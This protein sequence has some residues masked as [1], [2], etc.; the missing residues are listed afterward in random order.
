VRH[1]RWL[2]VYAGKNITADVSGMITEI[3]YS[4]QVAHLSDEVEITLEDRDRTWQ[5]DWF[6]AR[7]D[8]VTLSIGYDGEELLTCGD[9]EVDELELMGPPDT[10]QLKC[11]AAGV[12]PSIRTYR[13]EKYESTTLL[14][15]AKQVAERHGMT[16]VGAPGIV[17]VTFARLTQTHETDL[18]FLR[19]LAQ[20]H[21]YDFSIRGQKGQAVTQIVFFER[22]RLE[23]V[24]AVL[25][26][27]R[28]SDPPSALSD[29]QGRAIIAKS[30]EFKSKTQQI[31]KSA[32]MSYQ[33]PATKQLIVAHVNDD[34]PGRVPVGDDLNL[35]ER[36]ETPQQAQLKARSRLHDANMLQVTGRIETEG[37]T[38]LVA[39][40]NIGITGFGNFDGNYHVVRS[41]HRVERRTGYTTEVGIRK[42]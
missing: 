21:N 10:F 22:T 40:N 36:C 25:T 24:P 8:V 13:S 37:T 9:F 26:V 38:L 17:N 7:G 32:T 35:V 20:A 29:M 28:G 3:V 15:V 19:R 34:S 2:L 23:Q 41:K 14:D 12:T 31:Y 30:F 4:D 1:P 42:L 33:N 27:G 18:H 5:S 6:P 16:V 11:I 39:G